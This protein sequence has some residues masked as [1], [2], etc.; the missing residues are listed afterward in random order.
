MLSHWVQGRRGW[1]GAAGA[2]ARRAGPVLP[3]PA[4]PPM[5]SVELGLEPVEVA[6]LVVDVRPDQAALHRNPG[7]RVPAEFPTLRRGVASPAADRAGAVA[8]TIPTANAAVPAAAVPAAAVPA[9]AV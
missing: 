4:R 2:I 7:A 3:G 5:T 1:P 8:G 9:A 6:V